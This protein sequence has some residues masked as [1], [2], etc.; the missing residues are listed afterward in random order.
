MALQLYFTVVGASVQLEMSGEDSAMQI[1]QTDTRPTANELI[2]DVQKT[3]MTLSEDELTRDDFE[4]AF[5]YS[6]V[7]EFIRPEK[8]NLVSGAFKADMELK[9]EE[10]GT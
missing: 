1:A 4:Q 2:K 3:L 6:R 10:G 8:T 9:D 5:L 7:A